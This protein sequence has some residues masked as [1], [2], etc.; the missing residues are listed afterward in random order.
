MKVNPRDAICRRISNEAPLAELARR[1]E[2]EDGVEE[3]VIL[4]DGNFRTAMRAKIAH[5]AICI[6]FPILRFHID[7]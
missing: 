7:C 2:E 5:Y 3:N 1:L 4:V 6:A